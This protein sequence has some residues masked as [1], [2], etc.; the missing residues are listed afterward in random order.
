V[1]DL[2]DQALAVLEREHHLLRVEHEALVE[3]DDAQR[4]VAA[5]RWVIPHIERALAG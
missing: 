2:A 3:L 1:L 5:D 4:R